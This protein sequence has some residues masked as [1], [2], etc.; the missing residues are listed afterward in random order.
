[1]SHSSAVLIYPHQLYH[2]HPASAPDRLH[3]L[4]EDTL[5]FGDARYPARFHK[6]KLVYHRASMRRY[7]D[8]Q[9]AGVPRLYLDYA[10]NQ[11]SSDAV[12]RTLKAQGI[13]VVHVCDPTDDILER[14]IR[15]FCAYY[16]LGLVWHE[17]PNFLTTR[18]QIEAFYATRKRPDDYHQTDFYL[19]QRKRLGI[20]LDERGKPLGGKWT[21][22]SD[23]RHKL[24]AK[25]AIPPAP[26]R[27]APDDAYVTEARRYVAEHFP[28]HYGALGDLRYALTLTD[29]RQALHEFLRTRLPAFGTYQDAISQ[30]GDFLFHSVLSAPINAG[31]LSPHEVVQ[32]TLDYAAAHPSVSLASLEGFI[33]QIVGWREFMRAVYVRVGV[34]QRNSNYFQ[35][36]RALSPAWYTGELGI[37]PV[38]DAI[39]KALRTGY[40]HHI[41]RLMLI[42]NLMVLCQ[43]H[44]HEVYRWFMEL[45]IDAYDWVMVPNVYGMSQ[46]ADGGFITTKPY[47]SS[48][49]YVLK[50]S[51]YPRGAWCDLWDSLY[52]RFVHLHQEFFF[53]NPR[54]SV[55]LSH[56]KRLGDEG[57]RQHYQRAEQFLHTLA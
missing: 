48:S 36:E 55:M 10:H 29:A 27:S 11:T 9:L 5:F 22:D 4:I 42:G 12:F 26:P 46:Y 41:E 28:H 13:Q 47:I 40:A 31:I 37:P 1:M 16:E 14:R 20:L 8:E 30:R 7:Q 35:Q 51:D 56:L 6:L 43:I 18:A 53:S 49:N 17:S 34:R 2:P 50:M 25:V 33:R 21:Y 32:T 45:F 52:W 3:V 24:P 57:I 19:F 15:R 44:P 38:D 39:R 23:N 54:L